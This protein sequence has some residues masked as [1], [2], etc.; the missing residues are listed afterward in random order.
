[1]ED[2]SFFW[3]IHSGYSCLALATELCSSNTHIFDLEKLKFCLDFVA[4]YPQSIGL[5][6]ETRNIP[7]KGHWMANEPHVITMIQKLFT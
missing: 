3:R 7:Q 6:K 1:M 4:K 2:V 5:Q